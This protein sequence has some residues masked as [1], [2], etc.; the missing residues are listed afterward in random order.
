MKKNAMPVGRQG[1]TL[2]EM[3]IV[4]AII[5]LLSGI[6]IA[7]A[8]SARQKSR[9]AQAQ[10][11]LAQIHLALEAYQSEYGRYPIST[12]GSGVWDGLYS[13]YGDSSPNWI[14]G[15]TPTYM[16]AL[17]RSPNNSTDGSTNYIYHSDGKN[18]KLIW[19]G[20]EACA[21]VKVSHPQ[22]IDPA[23][24]CWAYGYWTAGARNW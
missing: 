21:K 15:L 8:N 3:L 6:I 4:I 11:D 14:A 24:D 17:P 5:G 10:T 9:I 19:H 16:L 23:R 2:I 18:Y 13:S 1:F 12:G 20:P 7:S 22:L